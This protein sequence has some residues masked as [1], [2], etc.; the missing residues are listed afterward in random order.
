MSFKTRIQRLRDVEGLF[1]PS[2]PETLRLLESL[3]EASG[4]TS[5]RIGILLVDDI[6]TTGS[7]AGACARALKEGGRMYGVD[8]V[9]YVLSWAHS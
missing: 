6:F 1:A 2:V 9:V 7:T 8:V 3:F 5:S 4:H